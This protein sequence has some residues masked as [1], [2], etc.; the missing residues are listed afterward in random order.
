MFLSEVQKDCLLSK[1][2]TETEERMAA[3]T[4]LWSTLGESS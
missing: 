3:L 1:T 4:A 2:M